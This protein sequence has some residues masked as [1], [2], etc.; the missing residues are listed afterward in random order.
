MEI[1]TSSRA[2]T[3]NKTVNLKIAGRFRQVPLW[4]TNLSFEVRPNDRFDNR[5]WKL[6]KPTLLLMNQVVKKERI[7]IK[8]VR[9]HSHF[10]LRGELPHAMGW[11]DPE[12]KGLFL[13][14]FDKETMLHELGHAKS[15]GYH[16]DQWAKN[17]LETYSPRFPCKITQHYLLLLSHAKPNK[18]IP[19]PTTIKPAGT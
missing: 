3:Q 18:R 8:W 1:S 9:V 7:Q 5:A 12:S 4:A 16:G 2:L 11:M 15:I 14:H 17:T 13:C 10:N 19:T 6:W